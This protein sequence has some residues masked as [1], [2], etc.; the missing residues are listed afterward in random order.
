MFLVSF[1]VI[2]AVAIGLLQWDYRIAVTLGAIAAIALQLGCRQPDIWSHSLYFIPLPI[3]S[4]AMAVLAIAIWFY[5]PPEP[6]SMAERH[7]R[8]AAERK[9]QLEKEPAKKQ[10][11]IQELARKPRPLFQGKEAPPVVDPAPLFDVPDQ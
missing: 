3:W 7:A 1:I 10:P 11:T 6:E 9:E 4:G 5:K 2:V 8:Q